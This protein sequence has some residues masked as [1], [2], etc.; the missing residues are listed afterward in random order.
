MTAKCH[1]CGTREPENPSAPHPVCHACRN[2][3]WEWTHRKE[4]DLVALEREATA[5]LYRAII[6]LRRVHA[7]RRGVGSLSTFHPPPNLASSSQPA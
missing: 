1:V 2:S 5:R 4:A 3:I 7:A 6:A